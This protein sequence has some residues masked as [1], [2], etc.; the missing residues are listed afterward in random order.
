LGAL[1]TNVALGALGTSG[2]N[3]ALEALWTNRPRLAVGSGRTNGALKPL[4]ADITLGALGTL[5][6][7]STNVPLR[8]LRPSNASIAL[9]TLR[10]NCSGQSVVSS[11][12]SGTLRP[13][14][15]DIALGSL[16]TL[17][18]LRAG[19]GSG[20][21]RLRKCE[22]KNLIWTITAHGD[23]GLGTNGDIANAQIRFPGVLDIENCAVATCGAVFASDHDRRIGS[24][25]LNGE[26]E[27]GV[28][29][30]R[31]NN[32]GGE[33]HAYVPFPGSPQSRFQL[34]LRNGGK[35][36]FRRNGG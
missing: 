5:R 24:G 33:I 25:G 32:G 2:A 3:I 35:D 14:W 31:V 10:T 29:C 8:T 22:I 16:R 1:R 4:Q 20:L 15:T 11:G 27:V 30:Q 26:A 6:P 13:L 19:K 34:S 18:T 12:A 21:G 17:R 23:S 28:R 7:Y 36:R 9:W